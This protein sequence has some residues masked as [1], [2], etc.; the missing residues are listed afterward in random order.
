LGWEEYYSSDALSNRGDFD[1]VAFRNPSNNE[2]I[3]TIEGSTSGSDWSSDAQIEISGNYTHFDAALRYAIQ[4]ADQAEL[5][6]V[7][8][9]LVTGQSL[10]AGTVPIVAAVLAARGISVEAHQFS[11][12]SFGA[13]IHTFLEDPSNAASIWPNL[14]A[15]QV[16]AEVSALEASVHS[17]VFSNDAILSDPFG[18]LGTSFGYGNANYIV[19]P[20][21]YM[22]RTVIENG[23]PVQKLD[24]DGAHS[25][26]A[27]IIAEVLMA[28][29][30][31]VEGGYAIVDQFGRL[32]VYQPDP[33]LSPAPDALLPLQ[34]NIITHLEDASSP[35]GVFVRVS[36]PPGATIIGGRSFADGTL[37]VEF[38]TADG[39]FQALLIKE[40]GDG[41]FLS[42]KRV[43]DAHGHELAVAVQL[44]G[45]QLTGADAENAATQLLTNRTEYA[46]F[47][48][49]IGSSLGKYFSGDDAVAEVV[50]SATLGTIALNF[51]QQLDQVLGNNSVDG[52]RAL[53]NST[54]SVFGNFS[55]ELLAQMK[56]AASGA[57]ASYLA[58]ELGD[59][60][61]VDGFGGE[62]L[63]TSASSVWTCRAFVPTLILI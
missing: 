59:A 47:L 34:G 17:F 40:L 41:S 39:G 25:H 32:A 9:V 38:K 56:G 12:P 27:R 1:A 19:G 6:G 36:I 11:A 23:I 5:D 55:S 37:S 14:T 43:L 61:G 28:A 49:A 51:G 54:E 29:G 45:E 33:N 57:F 24:Q 18:A 48:A 13:E 31:L 15:A 63:T 20:E 21:L 62:L 52:V 60:L 46:P 8:S 16:Q 2:L 7:N 42:V 35:L 44:D 22:E 26:S 53:A 30:Q 10:G 50:A 4:V 58:T 3:V